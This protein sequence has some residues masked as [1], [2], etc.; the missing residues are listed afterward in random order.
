MKY[1]HRQVEAKW[2]ALWDKEGLFES[3]QKSDKPKFYVADMF[4][5]PSGD[6]LHV[7]H[8]RSYIAADI[9]ARYKRMLGHNVLYPIGWD[10][11]GLPTERYS[12]KVGLDPAEATLKNT[13]RF[14]EQVKM[15]GYAK[16]WDR[17]IYTSDPEYYK[18]TQWL[19]KVLFDNGYAYQKEALVNWC[20][21]DKTVLANEQ[22]IAGKCE[23]CGSVV[24]QRLMNQ[25]FFKITDFAEELLAGLDKLDWP[26][27][28]KE[29]Q[30]NWIGKSEG[31]EIKFQI[32]NSKFEVMV[33][34]TRPDTIFGATFLV[35][36]PEH[37][38]V[39]EIV[40]P[41][42]RLVVDEYVA[43]AKTKSDL[44][45]M[46]QKDKT[47]IFSGAYATNP[48]TG[49]AIPIWIADYVMA[50]YGLGAIMAVPAHDERDFEFAGKYDLPIVRVIEGGEL[51]Y[52]SHGQLVASGEFNGQD[53]SQ[54][55]SDV[56]K[57]IGGL[58]TIYY[59]LRDW[60]VSRQRYWGAPIP[61]VYD[62]AGNPQSV[63]EEDLPVLLPADAEIKPTGVPPLATSPTFQA[64][65]EE[66]YGKGARRE[67]ET[68][69][70]FVDSSWYFLRYADPHNDKSFAGKEALKYWMPVDLYI[71]G[72]EHANG[73][74]LYARF[75]TKVLHRLGYLDFDEP[76]TR[77]RHQGFILAEDGSK[78]S[79]SK[80]NVVNPDELVA[81]VGAD[82]VR[83]YEMFL[84]PFDQTI[85][86]STNGV[87]GVRRFLDRACDLVHQRRAGKIVGNERAI[88]RLIK[89]VTEDIEDFK[90]NTAVS[91]L[92]EFVNEAEKDTDESFVE[93]FVKLLSVFAPHLAE[94]LWR[95]VLGRNQSVLLA[96]WPTWDAAKV[97]LTEVVVAVQEKGKLRGT[98]T[99]PVD[100]DE[101]AVLSKVEEDPKLAEVARS[102]KKRIFVKNRVINFV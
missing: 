8:P 61:I 4:A 44:D 88:N 46:M 29:S 25:W 98:V 95:E 99:M 40:T 75:V 56:V 58:E 102:A 86:W 69:D 84:G 72:R 12:L 65:V 74:L 96:E 19:F 100:A 59:K 51:P 38:L 76:F 97:E 67:V 32:P 68:M 7:G 71:G 15:F 89:R 57:A 21:E 81:S 79:K 92:M 80:G 39:A 20:P 66:K 50:G 78:M 1:D 35:L 62:P 82:T 87:M 90:F 6:G 33:F 11:F 36:A 83:M 91:G 22:V 23:R 30:R 54:A 47:G 53:S 34:T 31:A 94:E 37:Q 43:A 28:T 26:E 14:R 9:W 3:V 5:Y 13:E 70:T 63:A 10:S 27:S 17:E 41:E 55:A 42:Q 60:S 45:R 2:Q 77:L 101:V 85:P 48:A 49:E 24:E 64:G 93:P 52:S 73:H 16:N 18:W